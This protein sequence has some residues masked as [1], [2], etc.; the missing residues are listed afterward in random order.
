MD[1][2]EAE[3]AEAS[4]ALEAFGRGPG[5]AATEALEQ[6]FGRAGQSIA[7]VLSQAAKSGEV[8]F[9]R[10]SEAILADLARIA[11]EAVVARTGLGQTAQT[12][13]VN[14]PQGGDAS[15][16]VGAAGTIAS[17]VAAATARGGRFL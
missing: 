7:S 1:E 5:L 10:M 2:F 13:N 6:A 15:G 3:L 12:I 17:A 4:A 16:L 8:D 14:V 11:A 9:R